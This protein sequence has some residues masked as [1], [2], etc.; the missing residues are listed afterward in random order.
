MYAV[1]AIPN[2]DDP[3][4]QYSSE[5][6][7]HLTLLFLGDPG[8]T[9]AQLSHVTGYV[10]HSATL[11]HR[12]SLDVD[13]RGEL[14]PKKA[15]VLFFGKG[16][17][18]KQMLDFRSN[19]MKDTDIYDAFQKAPQFDGWVPHLTMGFPESPAK[20]DKR[21]YPGI[22]WVRFDQIALWTGDFEGPTFDLQTDDTFMEDVAMSDNNFAADILEHYGV[23][24]MKWG[25]RKKR[26]TS[27]DSA[28]TTRVS[29][30]KSGVKTQKTTRHLSNAEL[31]DAIQRMRLEQEFSRLSNGIEKTRVQKGRA[32]LA[33]VLGDAGKQTVSEVAKTQVKST[34]EA[35]IKKAAA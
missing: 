15:D 19:L 3:V 14:G 28:D 2:R 25:Q 32:F 1:V 9:P 33:K 22:T 8:W 12:F 16:W 21:D 6:I 29:A 4:W 5:K 35:G 7:P 23:K 17:N 11:L 26:Q 10:E 34:V 30:L 27:P 20:P 31:Q 18:S 13:R 24:G